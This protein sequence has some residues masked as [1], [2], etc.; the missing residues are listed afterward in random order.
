MHRGFR[1]LIDEDVAFDQQRRDAVGQ[2]ELRRSEAL[3]AIGPADMIDCDTRAMHDDLVKLIQRERA[4]RADIANGIER[5]VIAADAGIELQRDPHRF[6]LAGEPCAERVHIETVLRA[7]EGRAEAPVRR[8]EYID[9]A[10]EAPLSQ[11]RAVESALGGAAGMHALDHGAVLR[12]HQ[13]RRL[14]A[15]DPERMHGAVRIEPQRPRRTR[16]G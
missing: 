10:G 7:R 14:G 11:E 15:G 6:P 3:R 12:G 9:N 16:G 2:V 13:P 5:R 4:T 8:L 1:E